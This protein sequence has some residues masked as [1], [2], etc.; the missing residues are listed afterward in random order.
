MKQRAE[1]PSIPR[2]QRGKILRKE[3]QGSIKLIHKGHKYYFPKTKG[4]IK[5]GRVAKT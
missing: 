2:S 4:T 5:A 1:R 3:E